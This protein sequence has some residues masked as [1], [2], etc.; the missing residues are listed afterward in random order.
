M[1][2][3]L[4]VDLARSFEGQGCGMCSI[5]RYAFFIVT[6]FHFVDKEA[7]V[8]E[9]RAFLED[10]GRNQPCSQLIIKERLPWKGTALGVQKKAGMS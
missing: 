4:V 6:C 3:V 1:S 2:R 7:V 9:E 8:V 10:R 5:Q